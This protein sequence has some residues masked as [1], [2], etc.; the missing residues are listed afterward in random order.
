[1]PALPKAPSQLHPFR[2]RDRAVER[3][4]YVLDQ[5]AITGEIKPA[6]ADKWKKEP[7][8]VTA[9]PTGAHIFAAEY[10]AEEV[11]RWVYEKYGEKALYAEIERLGYAPRTAQAMRRR[12]AETQKRMLRRA[13]TEALLEGIAAIESV[14]RDALAP[15]APPRNVDRAPLRVGAREAAR[16]L[17]VCAATRRW[18]STGRMASAGR[19]P[20]SSAASV[21]IVERRPG[22]GGIRQR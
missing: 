15:D 7:L 11:R 16:A 18:P 4:N 3:R 14:Y 12:L 2:Q 9:R 20:R 5:M 19:H 6:E 1:M 22:C 8:T 13:R 21:S 17:D 10:F